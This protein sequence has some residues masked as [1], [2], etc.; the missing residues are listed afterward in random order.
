MG[1]ID[2]LGQV[3]LSKAEHKYI[4][5]KVAEHKSATGLSDDEAALRALKEMKNQTLSSLE[6]VHNQLNPKTISVIQPEDNKAPNIINLQTQSNAPTIESSG[7]VDVGNTSGDGKEMGSG[8]AE[9]TITPE[10]GIG[11][12]PTTQEGGNQTQTEGEKPTGVKRAV[13]D[14]VRADRN[15]PEVNIPAMGSDA[16]ELHAAKQRVDSGQSDPRELVNRILTKKE[17]YKNEDDVMDM[18]YYAHQLAAKETDLRTNL[19]QADNDLDKSHALG[20]LQQLSD[21]IDRQTE[22]ARIAGNQWSRVGNRMQPVIDSGF[23]P[24]RERGF[25]KD[26]YG[27]EIPKEAKLKIDEAIKQRDEALAEKEKLEK[28]ITNIKAQKEISKKVKKSNKSHEDFVN[29]RKSYAQQLR[30]AKEKFENDQKDRGIQKMGAGPTL[31]PEMVKIV[32]KIVKSYVE[33]GINKLDEIVS[34]VHADVKDAIEGI[35]KTHIVD[36]IAGRYN[37]NTSKSPLE[38]NN[39]WVKANQKQIAAEFQLKQIKRKA[40]ESSK[41]LY[42][43]TLM[44]LGRTVRLFVL[45]GT[46]VLYKLS[47]AA[48]IG[49]ALKRLPEQAIGSVYS[50]AF[51]GIAEKAPIEGQLN[52][53]AELKFYKE[54]FNPKK[55][56]VNSW[57]ILK[58]GESLLSQKY[59]KGGY[60][61]IPILYLPTDLHQII[62][63]PLKRA[64]FE[65]S[66][67]NAMHNMAAQGMDIQDPLVVNAME[68]ASYKRAMYEIFQEDNALSKKFTAWKE[69]MEKNGNAGATAKFVADFLIPVSTVPT[70]IVKRLASTSPLGLIRG[71]KMVIDA[72]R[73]G[74]E[75]LQPDEADAVMRQLKQGTLG[76]ALWL[77]GWFGYKSFGGLYNK[78]DP[79]KKRNTGDLVSDEMS[80]DGHMIAKPVQHALPLEG[81][82]MAATSRRIYE[83]YREGGSGT[84]SAIYHAGMGTIG[85]ALKQVPIISTVVHG[86]EATTNPYDADKFK[87]DMKGR[88]VPQILKET[89]IVKKPEKPSKASGSNNSIPYQ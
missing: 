16:D 20:Q 18:Q 23:N 56:A 66:F 81:I 12:P 42:Q 7:T 83:H 32:G 85:A 49:G 10:Q 13:T 87:E 39:D 6:D 75:S 54:F 67:R 74:I 78:F 57:E 28:E 48:V 9:P 77:I 22:A 34:K 40:F 2:C 73:K 29:E 11:Q 84:F 70:N 64:T 52:V 37:P 80:I 26:A 43:K 86:V 8:N 31:T 89:G 38:L 58:K 53:D 50:Q 30:E 3:G 27:G 35:S 61:H 68:T 5:D 25:I 62:K 55:F 24:V 65:A 41:N 82:Q 1:L 71:S 19:S 33:E 17:G 14:Q 79:D 45:S 15:L 4:V 21:E 59:G 76:T 72:Y 63:D 51:K 46:N 69:Q 60:E 88:V 44:W 36:I 47:S